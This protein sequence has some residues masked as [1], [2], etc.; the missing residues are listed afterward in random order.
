MYFEVSVLQGR[1]IQGSNV[2]QRLACFPLSD[3]EVEFS[4]FQWKVESLGHPSGD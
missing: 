4:R 3:R 2:S 1:N